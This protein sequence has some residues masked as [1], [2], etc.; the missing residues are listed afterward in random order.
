MYALYHLMPVRKCLI[1]PAWIL[2]VCPTIGRCIKVLH[3]YYI[4][5]P[6]SSILLNA[7]NLFYTILPAKYNCSPKMGVR[8]T[9]AF[10]NSS[11]LHHCVITY[12]LSTFMLMTRL[13][14]FNNSLYE[15][16]I[17]QNIMPKRFVYVTM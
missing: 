1:G 7:F 16:N 9:G 6:Y 3:V 4:R 17:F 2:N 15:E 8:N 5:E 14:S 11:I 13:K 10:Q 12:S